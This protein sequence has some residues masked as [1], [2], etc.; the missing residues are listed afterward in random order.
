MSSCELRYLWGWASWKHEWCV[1][2]NHC[3]SEVPRKAEALS[4]NRSGRQ[5]I[6][7][8]AVPL[9]IRPPMTQPFVFSCLL[10]S[11]HIFSG[12]GCFTP[13]TFPTYFPSVTLLTCSD[14]SSRHWS[15]TQRS[16]I[17]EASQLLQKALLFLLGYFGMSNPTGQAE[18]LHIVAHFPLM[19]LPNLPQPCRFC[20][21]SSKSSRTVGAG[22]QCGGG[23]APHMV[24]HHAPTTTALWGWVTDTLCAVSRMQM[25]LE[26]YFGGASWW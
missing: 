16:D 1:P 14:S 24:F 22:M 3:N 10:V 11:P 20:L 9:S 26:V 8:T 2:M 4:S 25:D 7:V 17:R 23:S 15:K 6:V 18:T 21:M 12:L 13:A 19:C 5:Q